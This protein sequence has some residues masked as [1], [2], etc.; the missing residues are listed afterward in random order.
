[1]V[2]DADSCTNTRIED[3]Y[4]VF[5]DDYVAVKSGWD[6]YGIAYGIP[7]KQLVVRRL[8]CISPTS[9]VSSTVC[10]YNVRAGVE[11]AVIDAVVSSIRVPLRRLFGAEAAE[12]ASKYYK[13][14]FKTLKLKVGKNLNADIEVLPAI[15]VA[16]P[17]CQFILDA[18]EVYNSDESVEVLE[19]LHC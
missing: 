8:T 17:D 13:K 19:K 16:H 4:I 12:L 7:T 10:E 2:Y 5:G 6:E 15:R 1:M 3:C 11:V 9:A 18:N 14:G